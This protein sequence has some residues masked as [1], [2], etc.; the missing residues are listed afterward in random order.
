MNYL[1]DTSVHLGTST[2]NFDYVEYK[3]VRDVGIATYSNSF[4]PKNKGTY[5]ANNSNHLTP[6]SNI[7]SNETSDLASFNIE[8]KVSRQSSHLPHGV[9]HFIH[10]HYN[11]FV[12]EGKN[13]INLYSYHPE[14][15][16]ERNLSDRIH[17]NISDSEPLTSRLPLPSPGYPDVPISYVNKMYFGNI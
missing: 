5:F 14:L 17:L 10:P 13:Q 7:Q 3:G 1:N 16:R 8:D 12:N 9:S 4:L 15:A 2:N 6:L 11:E